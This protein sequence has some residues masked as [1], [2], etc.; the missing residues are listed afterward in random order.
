MNIL[1]LENCRET[2]SCCCRL[3]VRLKIW[4]PT[5]DIV[6]WAEN[7]SRFNIC[8]LK[9]KW[10]F[11]V[12]KAELY[13][14][15]SAVAGAITALRHHTRNLDSGLQINRHPEWHYTETGQACLKTHHPLVCGCE[16]QPCMITSNRQML[17]IS[18]N[19]LTPEGNRSEGGS[20]LVLRHPQRGRK[21]TRTGRGRDCI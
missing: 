14:Y 9:N 11:R 3:S 5:E 6:K 4:R 16:D 1:D 7:R 13:T 8:I 20:V 19:T 2:P 18:Q 12:E 17:R 10:H 15:L 21:K